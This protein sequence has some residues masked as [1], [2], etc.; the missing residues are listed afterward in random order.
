MFLT[1]LLWSS[2]NFGSLQRFTCK[3]WYFDTHLRYCL[4]KL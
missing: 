3:R 2:S 4:Y 1:I